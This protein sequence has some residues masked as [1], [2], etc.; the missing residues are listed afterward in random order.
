[1]MKKDRF[2][3]INDQHNNGPELKLTSLMATYIS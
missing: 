1:M 3:L 2:E